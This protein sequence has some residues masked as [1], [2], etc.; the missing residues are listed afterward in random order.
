MTL[1]CFDGGEGASKV[2]YIAMNGMSV[3]SQWA[4]RMSSSIASHAWPEINQ[5]NDTYRPN[6]AY[7]GKDCNYPTH[8]QP[9]PIQTWLIEEPLKTAWE[10]VEQI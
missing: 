3:P 4:S 10:V 1:V 8:R 7:L 2:F 9:Y 6:P 5:Q